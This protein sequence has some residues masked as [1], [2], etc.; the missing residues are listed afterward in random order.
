MASLPCSRV[1]ILSPAS[2]ETPEAARAA[3]LPIPLSLLI[4]TPIDP[5][6][7]NDF[8]RE[9]GALAHVAVGVS[10]GGSLQGVQCIR[11]ADQA[12]RPRRGLANPRAAVAIEDANQKRHR[13]P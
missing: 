4:W 5:P 11:G 10:Q 9:P 3:S 13:L 2:R 8:G 6:S 12:Q 1:T 7:A